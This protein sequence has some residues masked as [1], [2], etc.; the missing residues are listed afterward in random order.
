MANTLITAAWAAKIM[1]KQWKVMMSG[2]EE[3]IKA[4]M[5]EGYALGDLT[6]AYNY[7]DGKYT[8]RVITAEEKWL[9]WLSNN[10]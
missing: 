8:V 3:A 5:A 10:H 9:D 4:K 6:L 1:E 2:V 7:L